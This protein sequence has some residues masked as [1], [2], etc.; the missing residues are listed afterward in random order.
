MGKVEQLA[1]VVV[2]GVPEEEIAIYGGRLMDLDKDMGLVFLFLFFNL[3]LILS[4]RYQF[5]FLGFNFFGT[6]WVD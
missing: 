5:L 1:M 4:M 6:I 2:C 3:F